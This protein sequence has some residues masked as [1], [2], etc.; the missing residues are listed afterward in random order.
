MYCK[1]AIIA[2]VKDQNTFSTDGT[3]TTGIWFSADT[4]C[5]LLELLPYHTLPRCLI[6]Y[7]CQSKNRLIGIHFAEL[8]HNKM[9]DT[10]EVV[11]EEV[12]YVLIF[13]TFIFFVL[14]LNKIINVNVVLDFPNIFTTYLLILFVNTAIL[15][16]GW[17][18]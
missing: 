15:L 13:F 14:W 3:V 18:R 2:P 1:I 7:I 16:K 5:K 12:Q 11:E 6:R 17:R 10:E 4:H 9:S 8:I